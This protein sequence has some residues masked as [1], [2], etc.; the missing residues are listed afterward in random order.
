MDAILPPMLAL[1]SKNGSFPF[2]SKY[3]PLPPNVRAVLGSQVDNNTGLTVENRSS[4]STNGWFAPCHP[5]N[6]QGLLVSSIPLSI[7]HAEAWSADGQIY[8]RDLDS[9]FGTFVNGVKLTGEIALKNGDTLRLG[10]HIDRN[11][12]TPAY[13]T[14]EHL[15]PVVAKVTCVGVSSRPTHRA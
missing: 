7:N 14:D 13:V 8:I 2:A 9:A 11:A 12:N 10:T 5:A 3:I 4:A 1:Q 15:L 6:G